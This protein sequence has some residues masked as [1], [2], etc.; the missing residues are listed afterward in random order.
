M[1]KCHPPS[2][3]EPRLYLGGFYEFVHN[4]R[5]F[6]DNKITHILS[7]GYIPNKH[8]LGTIKFISPPQTLSIQSV[9]NTSADLLSKFE[10]SHQFLDNALSD[11]NSVVYVHCHMGISRSATIMIS[12]LMKKYNLGFNEAH[13]KVKSFRQCIDPNLGFVGQLI[14]YERAI[15]K[16]AKSQQ[17]QLT[18]T[19][20]SPTPIS[21]LSPTPISPLS[22]L[23]PTPILTP[24]SPILT[25]TSP[26]IPQ[27]TI[28]IINSP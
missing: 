15:N 27:L 18:L 3:I 26:I 16:E 12:Y 14:D 23:S 13:S 22:P 21:P 20:T 4:K 11:P 6:K 25:P 5:W 19:P 24:T 17:P 7:V 1:E 28:T 9:D 10:I 2:K 8:V